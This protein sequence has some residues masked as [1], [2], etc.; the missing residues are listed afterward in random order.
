MRALYLASG[1]NRLATAVSAPR[2]LQALALETPEGAE[3]WL[4]NL[5]GE[6][7]DVRLEGA[8]PSRIGPLDADTFES[9][10]HV[11]G[12]A[13]TASRFTGPLTLTPYAVVKL[14]TAPG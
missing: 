3:I 4:A 10:A 5:T 8:A 14:G 13:E 11:D 7:I 1:A 9:C 2:D 6:S 12:F